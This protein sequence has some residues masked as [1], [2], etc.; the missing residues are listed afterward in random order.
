MFKVQF[1]YL[2]DLEIDAFY[3]QSNDGLN[4]NA[5][6]RS[7]FVRSK[8]EISA[9]QPSK[10]VKWSAVPFVLNKSIVIYVLVFYASRALDRSDLS[11]K[12]KGVQ[13]AEEKLLKDQVRAESRCR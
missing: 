9:N 11:R 7:N 3:S 8:L 10:G 1:K 4:V 12:A 5:E 13:E 6:L 2:G